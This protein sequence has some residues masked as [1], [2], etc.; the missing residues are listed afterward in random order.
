[1]N[2]MPDVMDRDHHA[3]NAWARIAWNGACPG[4]GGLG[5]GAGNRGF[6][7]CQDC[8]SLWNPSRRD[9]EYDDDYPAQRGH[10]DQSIAACKIRTFE[11]WCGQLQ[12]PLV[13]RDVLEVGFGGG[14]TLTW[15]RDRG[16]RVF[17]VE[18]VAANRA[19]AVQAGIP[20]T[21]VKP[22]LKDFQDRQFDLVF[23]LDSFEHE[24]E[25]AAHL[26]RLNKLTKPGSRALLVLPVADSMSRRL[27]GRWWPHDIRDHWVFYSTDGLIRLWRDH[28]WRLA[29]SFHPSK[30]ISGS[31]IARHLEIK[32][33]VRLPPATLRSTAIWLNF[34]ERGLVFEKR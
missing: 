7:R 13:G 3:R 5:A 15:M 1:M 9:Y 20:S 25:P 19:A 17:G 29:S 33:R 11:H 24:E 34:G 23:Y 32:T 31:T 28:G 16:A 18:P 30:Y 6:Q 14:L 27:L 10:D 22:S 12:V 26:T 4:C 8:E 2:T 21:N